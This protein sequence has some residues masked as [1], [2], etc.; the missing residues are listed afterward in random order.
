MLVFSILTNLGKK[1]TRACELYEVKRVQLD[2]LTAVGDGVA[3]GFTAEIRK[4]I[5]REAQRFVN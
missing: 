2:K 1:L 3:V 4:E 5:R